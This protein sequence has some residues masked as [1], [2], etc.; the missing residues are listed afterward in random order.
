[1]SPNHN[2]AVASFECLPGYDSV[3]HNPTAVL[4][5]C[6]NPSEKAS[7]ETRDFRANV[8]RPNRGVAPRRVSVRSS[9]YSPR[10]NPLREI[11]DSCGRGRGD[12]GMGAR[13][14][15]TVANFATVGFKWRGQDSNL[16]PR[17]YE[18]RELPGCSTPR[19]CFGRLGLLLGGSGRSSVWRMNSQEK[20]QCWSA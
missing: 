8:A 19:Q 15:P 7:L 18:P 6:H 10:R 20:T 17:G 12:S 16:R 14:N 13:E 5:T 2:P 11:S 4:L 1:M 9:E 3:T